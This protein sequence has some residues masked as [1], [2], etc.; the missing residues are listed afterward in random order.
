MY[1]WQKYALEV[2]TSRAGEKWQHS[3]VAIIT[4]RQNGK[5]SL[6]MPRI[7]DGLQRGEKILHAAQTREISR[8][9]L[10]KLVPK[11]PKTWKVREANGQESIRTP[12][13]GVYRVVAAQRGARGLSADLLIIDELREFEDFDFIAAAAPTLTASENPQTL[14]VSNAGTERSVVLNDLRNR[15]DDLA[16]M[17]WSAAEHRAVD[18]EDG[19]REAN[20]AMD[21][22]N[23]TLDR[24]RAFYDRYERA[25]ELAIFETEH[26]CRWVKSMMPRL[27][28]DSAWQQ[29]RGTLETPRNPAMGVS[30][31]PS[32]KRASAAIAWAQSDGS[33]GVTVTAEVTGQ[34]I[35]IVDLAVDL[36]EQA[37][38]QGVTVVGFDP[39]TDQHLAR[40][41]PVTE[42]I[43]GQ[44]FA[45]AS[46]RFVSSVETQ[47]LRWQF[48]DSIST[49]LPYVSRKATTGRSYMADRADPDR[50]ITAAL[51][52][53]RAVW[54]ASNP[55]ILK[56]A[57]Y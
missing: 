41:F 22:G 13:G 49:D 11:M 55:Q 17:E 19:W 18:D 30:V 4:A 54:L 52:A 2:M 40:H 45:N 21:H 38:S 14:Y 37:Q 57:I 6:L 35:N 39:W 26:L 9:L 34:P 3:E 43:N 48:A 46:E 23:M 47:G 50:S 10:L 56:P 36:V 20:P 1:P 28:Q 24:I 16:Y 29:C 44:E 51:A 8:E 32:G 12:E 27:V 42:A 15:A 25:G 53:V 5:T 31:D 33:I 7:V